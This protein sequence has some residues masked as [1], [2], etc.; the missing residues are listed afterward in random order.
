MFPKKGWA[1][2]APAGLAQGITQFP[3]FFHAGQL[4]F[5]PKRTVTG[6]V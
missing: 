2:G 4:I 3:N 6:Q 5:K 1:G